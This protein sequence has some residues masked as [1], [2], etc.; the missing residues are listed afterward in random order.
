ME[1][2]IQRN[3]EYHV[4]ALI[5]LLLRTYKATDIGVTDAELPT[6]ELLIRSY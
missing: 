6:Q 4:A 2:L 5:Q 3:C 1:L